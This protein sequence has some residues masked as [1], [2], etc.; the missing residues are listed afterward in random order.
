MEHK[1][2]LMLSYCVDESVI[3]VLQCKFTIFCPNIKITNIETIS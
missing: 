2:Q 1:P 3:P